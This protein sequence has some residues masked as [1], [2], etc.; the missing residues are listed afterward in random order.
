[1]ELQSPV[2]GVRPKPEFPPET[3]FSQRKR[4][5]VGAPRPPRAPAKSCPPVSRIFWENKPATPT[6]QVVSFKSKINHDGKFT[7][8]PLNELYI[9]F[10]IMQ[11]CVPLTTSQSPPSLTC[12]SVLM[13]VRSL[14]KVRLVKC[15]KHGVVMMARCTLSRS[16]ASHSGEHWIGN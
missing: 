8:N 7:P 12:N 13:C 10:V 4:T 16:R 5:P 11:H 15:I 1:M 14:G 6:L 3:F 2:R 9:G